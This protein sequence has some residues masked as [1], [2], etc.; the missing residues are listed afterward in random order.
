LKRTLEKFLNPN[1]LFQKQV[2]DIEL[3]VPE[4][5]KKEAT[6]AYTD[7]VT[8][9]VK[10]Q[11]FENLKFNSTFV[12]VRIDRHGKVLDTELSHDG[13]SVLRIKEKNP[14]NFLKNV[15]STIYYLNPY[16]KAY[17]K[18]QTGLRSIDFGSIFLFLNGF[19][20]A[21]YGDRGDDWLGLDV[22]KTQGTSRY[23]GSR[24]LIGRVEIIDD[25][26]SFKPISSRE[27]LKKT[28]AFVELKE[29]FILEAV[30][31][32]EKF[33]VDGLN[34]DSI[35]DHLRDEVRADTGMDW[36][37]TVEHYSESWDKK[38]ERIAL[39]IMT[40]IGSS[41]DRIISFWFNPALLEGV[42]D[43]RAE[44]VEQLLTTIDGFDSGQVEPGLKKGIARLRSLVDQR[45]RESRAARA[46]AANLRLVVA[47]H[48]K[49]L[50]KLEKE[51]ETFQAQ[52]LFLQSLASLEAKNLVA[53]H[54]EICLN[55]SI[56]DNHMGKAMKA[57]RGLPGTDPA[58]QELEKI[59]LANKRIMAIAQ[60]ATKANFKSSSTKE[61]TD[62]PAFFE[63]YINNV[64]REFIA[65]GL[66]LNVSN[67]VTEPFEVKVRRI[68]LS[69]LI[70][71]IISNA[72]KAQARK[73]DIA[74]SKIAANSIS[75]SF[76]DD[77]NGLSDA[78]RDPKEIFELGV[79]TTKGSGLGLYHCRQIVQTLGGTI[80]AIP[81]SPKGL[82]LRVIVTR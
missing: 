56:I 58:L 66:L 33:V 5:A 62:I 16:K 11:I 7:R 25:E 77:G 31:R 63:Q 34:W 60:F 51:A 57:L 80:Q 45:E 21:P 28:A 50:G 72:N 42:M 3:E 8:G 67:L 36:T 76:V 27:G 20:I 70:D 47:E 71:N 43:Q 30:R 29:E 52:T 6:A 78:I 22:R 59:A 53:F 15:S 10:N 32:L 23:L 54:H 13:E 39:T 44:E 69:I 49:K 38:R 68:E 18:R 74:I 4:L 2:F 81:V 37:K 79:T 35:P 40:F 65:T 9:T 14:Y 19:R 1:Q 12:R 82:E 55:S 64:A 24:D 61:L 73:L 41:Q 17:F 26:E 46:E 48:S 75:I